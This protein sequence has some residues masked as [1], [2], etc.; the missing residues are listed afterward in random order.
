MLVRRRLSGKQPAD[1]TADG[2]HGPADVPADRGGHSKRWRDEEAPPDDGHGPADGP[3]DRGGRSSRSKRWRSGCVRE[4][5]VEEVIRDDDDNEE[6]P[7]DDDELVVTRRALVT[8]PRSL[9]D[10]GQRAKR[11][12]LNLSEYEALCHFRVPLILWQTLSMLFDCMGIIPRDL[13]C[14]DMF[15]GQESVRKAWSRR[16]YAAV[17]YEIL[18]GGETMDLNS[19][20]GWVT[21]VIFIMRLVLNGFSSWGTVCSSWI[22]VCLSTSKR[23]K[24][25]PLG[26]QDKDFVVNGNTM[27]ARMS[28]LLLLLEARGCVWLLEQPATSLMPAGSSQFRLPWG[29]LG[30]PRGSR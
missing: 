25:N 9:V 12:G 14:V 29:A 13:H 26:D 5:L 22:W 20:A 2:G 28:A 10:P 23:T 15:A 4:G 11:F 30:H 21:A 1:P 7:P 18:K 16:G 27:V 24:E 3:A 19:G 8:V 17:G 6:A